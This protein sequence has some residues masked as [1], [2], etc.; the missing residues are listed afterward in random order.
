MLTWLVLVI[1]FAVVGIFATIMIIKRMKYNKKIVIFEK[2][3]G[4]WEATKQDR[5]MDIKFSTAGDLIIHLAKH[6]LYRPY[7]QIQTGRRTYWYAIREDGEWINFGIED[8]DLK[9]K[10]MDIHFLDK[11][12]RYARTQIQKGLKDRYEQPTFWEKYG[13]KLIGIAYASILGVFVWLCL[14][15]FADFAGTLSNVTEAV[16]RLIDRAD[17]ILLSMDNVCSGGTG[18]VP[19]T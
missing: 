5:A 19:V 2:I 18:T 7:P 6:K 12:M 13:M 10:R 16:A 17:G 4:S 14:R 15:E 3:G 11:E 1:V 8:I 9:M